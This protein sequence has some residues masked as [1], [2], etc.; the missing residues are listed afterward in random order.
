MFVDGH[1]N[2]VV[3][4]IDGHAYAALVSPQGVKLAGP[5]AQA[6]VAGEF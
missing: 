5:L 2:F 6:P 4:T 1:A 3:D